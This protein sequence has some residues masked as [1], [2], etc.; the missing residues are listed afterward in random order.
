MLVKPV[1]GLYREWPPVGA[2]IARVPAGELTAGGVDAHL[3]KVLSVETWVINGRD[4]SR[5][6]ALLERGQTAGTLVTPG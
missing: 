6:A 2:P 5:L 4:P 3:A 1:D